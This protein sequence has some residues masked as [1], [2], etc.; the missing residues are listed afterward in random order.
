MPGL[1]FDVLSRKCR[2]MFTVLKRWLLCCSVSRDLFAGLVSLSNLVF[3]CCVQWVM[4]VIVI[5]LFEKKGLF[6]LFLLVYDVYAVR[7]SMFTF[8]LEIIERLC[9]FI[10]AL[11]TVPFC[12]VVVCF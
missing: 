7:R 10:V 1:N 2:F 6:S 8:L 12:R 11:S 3:Y 5:A 4:S 9:F